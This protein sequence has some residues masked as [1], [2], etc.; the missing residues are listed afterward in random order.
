M[1]SLGAQPLPVEA[2]VE[3]PSLIQEIPSKRVVVD[4]VTD[5]VGTVAWFNGRV[6]FISNDEVVEIP[7]RCR[8]TTVYGAASRM[9][10]TA[11]QGLPKKKRGGAPKRIHTILVETIERQK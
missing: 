1:K 4:K 5:N 6:L 8:A 3:S 10:R 7:A 9:V 11:K 2:E